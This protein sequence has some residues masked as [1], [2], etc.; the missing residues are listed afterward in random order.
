MHD[1][2]FLYS[3]YHSSSWDEW[4]VLW[5]NAVHGVIFEKVYMWKKSD[6]IAVLKNLLTLFLGPH[7]NWFRDLRK[8]KL[9]KMFR[10]FEH[11]RPSLFQLKMPLRFSD[12]LIFGFFGFFSFILFC[13]NIVMTFS[14]R[15]FSWLK[16]T[17]SRTFFPLPSDKHAS[18]CVC[19]TNFSFHLRF[20]FYV[21]C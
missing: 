17:P 15:I 4:E 7:E 6:E 19:D 18:H 2:F 20:I 3:S 5:P 21:L 13:I 16:T 1:W 9:N 14:I 10:G 8:H 11:K 12:Y